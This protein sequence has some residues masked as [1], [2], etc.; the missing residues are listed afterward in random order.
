MNNRL[1][2]FR[3]LVLV[4]L[5]GA[6]AALFQP[7]PT[8]EGLLSV[9]FFDVGQGDA[10]FIETPDG[11]QVLVDGGPSGAVLHHLAEKMSFFDR[12][13]DM[14]IGTHQDLDHVAGLNEVL[15]NYAVTSI[16]RTEGQGASPAAQQFVVAAGTETPNIYFARAGQVFAL[17]ASTTL[18]VLSPN[19]DTTD[20]ASNTSS[21]VAL[22]SYGEIDFLLTGDAPAG[23]ERYL[24]GAFGADLEAEVLKLGHHGSNTSS[25]SGFLATVQPE[26]AVVSAGRNNRYNHPHP[27]V[28]ERVAEVGAT[29]FS[30]T[31]GTV[32]FYTDGTRVWSE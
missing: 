30:T 1:Q 27:A 11:V 14:V 23:I 13:L 12:T 26:Y 9:H 4:L 5:L 32:S 29:V 24:V 8:G 21:V 19:S 7:P 28:L 10:I 25:E 16:L 31:Q 22:L 3:A 6:T 17:G 2:L 15:A 20:W 18:T